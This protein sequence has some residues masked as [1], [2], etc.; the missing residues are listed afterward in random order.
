MGFYV[1]LG[2]IAILTA[3]VILSFL[4]PEK[5]DTN[6]ILNLRFRMP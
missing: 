6:S 3:F 4:G 1:F 5:S 2:I